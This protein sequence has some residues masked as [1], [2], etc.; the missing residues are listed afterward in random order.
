MVQAESVKQETSPVA[1]IAWFP[2]RHDEWHRHVVGYRQIADERRELEIRSHTSW[3]LPEYS[4]IASTI[5][6]VLEHDGQP[7]RIDDVVDRMRSEF[8]IAEG[9][10]RAYCDAAMFVV[11]D[12][13]IRLRQSEEPY[14]YRTRRS[15][16]RLACSLWGSG[17]WWYGGSE[18]RLGRRSMEEH[19]QSVGSDPRKT[20]FC[21][22]PAGNP[23]R[24]AKSIC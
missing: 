2:S 10:A 8:G 1:S 4:G 20:G 5:G 12:G 11:E 13:W 7:M 14:Q 21:H 23:P 17:S 19:C 15:A 24:A 18:T 9:S 16:P 22:L 6:Q 3:G